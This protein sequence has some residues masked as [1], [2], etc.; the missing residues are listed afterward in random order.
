MKESE[1]RRRNNRVLEGS[2]GITGKR[3]GTNKD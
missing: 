2:G 1:R 3:R